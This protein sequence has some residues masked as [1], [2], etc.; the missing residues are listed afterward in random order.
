MTTQL[1]RRGNDGHMGLSRIGAST[2][3]F[4]EHTVLPGRAI[5]LFCLYSKLR[6]RQEFLGKNRAD[7]LSMY[8]R[9][10]SLEQC[11]DCGRDRMQIEM[12]LRAEELR[13]KES[14]HQSHR[15]VLSHARQM[16]AQLQELLQA[17]FND[18]LPPKRDP[19]EEYKQHPWH[20][21]LCLPE[22]REII[23]AA[24]REHQQ[25][26]DQLRK[27]GQD[28]GQDEQ[29]KRRGASVFMILKDIL[30]LIAKRSDI[31]QGSL[32]N[33]REHPTSKEKNFVSISN[34]LLGGDI[35]GSVCYPYSEHCRLAETIMSPSDYLR[36][37]WH[38]ACSGGIQKAGPS[39]GFLEPRERLMPGR[40]RTAEKA[41]LIL[42]VLDVLA[43]NRTECGTGWAQVPM[44]DLAELLEI[45]REGKG[46]VRFQELV[47]CL[48]GCGIIWDSGPRYRR[49]VRLQPLDPQ[50]RPTQRLDTE[51]ALQKVKV[52]VAL[53]GS[54]GPAL[55]L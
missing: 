33:D 55:S 46:Y 12:E 7:V 47:V 37:A 20:P 8:G 53:S 44:A 34:D 26:I 1:A 30:A 29:N 42:D 16:K 40:K 51:A 27:Q 49:A 9:S 28:G 15:A 45:P 24:W 22:S 54:D 11:F 50:F 38:F 23:H 19:L 3:L 31:K 48:A 13:A 2:G 18:K 6:N 43:E 32:W 21:L 36:H 35:I 52:L 39:S 5:C 14:V 41:R 10:S 4:Y 25:A 17:P